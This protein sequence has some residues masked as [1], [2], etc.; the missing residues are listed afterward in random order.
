MKPAIASGGRRQDQHAAD[1]PRDLVEPELEARRDAEVAA[2]AADRPEQVGV[3][4]L[5]RRDAG[6]AVGGHE[7]GGEQRVDRHA[8]LADEV[9][10]PAAES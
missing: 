7:L 10:D 2:A 4:G 3:G 8:V 6:R 1:D 9:A 5:R